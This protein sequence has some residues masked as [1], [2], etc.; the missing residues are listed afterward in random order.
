LKRTEGKH[1]AISGSR[2]TGSVYAGSRRLIL[3]DMEGEEETEET[4]EQMEQAEEEQNNENVDNE[5]KDEDIEMK[6][7]SN[8]N[9][10]MNDSKSEI[11]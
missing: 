10:P 1:I 11:K 6:Q 5:N 9:T 8:E 2:G 7:Q 3:F 4:E